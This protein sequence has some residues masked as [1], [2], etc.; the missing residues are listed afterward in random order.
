MLRWERLEHECV[1]LGLGSVPLSGGAE[2][3]SGRGSASLRLVLLAGSAGGV[4]HD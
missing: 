4:L 3:S 2:G 1:S